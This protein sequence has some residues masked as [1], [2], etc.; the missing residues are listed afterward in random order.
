MPQNIN[1]KACFIIPRVLPELLLRWYDEN[2]RPLPW[3]RDIEP[4]HVWLSEIM[5]QQTGAEVVKDYYRRFLEAL[6]TIE[7]LAAAEEQKV[8]KLWEGLGYYSRARNL[9]K[10]AQMLVREYGG[11]MPDTYDAILRLPGVGA[12]TAGAIA[13]ICYNAP[14]PAVDGNVI[15]V[16]SRIV[17]IYD[18]MTE[19]VKKR[20]A[21]SLQEIYPAQRCGDLTQSLMELG[22]TVCIPNG[23]PKCQSCEAALCPAAAICAANRDSTASALPVKPI[24]QAK[25]LEELTVFLFSCG[26][27]IALRTRVTKGLLAGLWELPNVPGKLSDSDAVALAAAWGTK[28]Q[29]LIKASE[30]S[31]VFT[32]IK[33]DMLCYD[34]KCREQPPC[35]TWVSRRCLDDDYALPTAFKKLL[36]APENTPEA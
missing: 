25:R 28:P 4:Y 12:Y 13:S 35:F 16:I 1:S 23:Q 2:A 30:R 32:H 21:S 22:A 8:L 29:A 33:W 7:A 20:I 11:H 9:L 26:N 14:V 19:S 3:R 17:G 36:D 24:R 6:P 31:H 15:R 10:A 18:E 5:L 34:I 27:N